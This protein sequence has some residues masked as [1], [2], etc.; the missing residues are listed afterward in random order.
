MLS[1]CDQ[2]NVLFIFIDVTW[3]FKFSRTTLIVLAFF[4]LC[5]VVWQ[6]GVGILG[7]LLLLHGTL[8]VR[9][10]STY[11][12]LLNVY[13]AAQHFVLKGHNFGVFHL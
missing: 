8:G 5:H 1:Y 10:V 9:A 11:E 3:D 7:L 4:W 6:I 12:M 13:R 2:F